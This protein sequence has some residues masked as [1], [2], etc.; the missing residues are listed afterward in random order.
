M[1]HFFEL[2]CG[3]ALIGGLSDSWNLLTI[4]T[5]SWNDWSMFIP[6]FA[7]HSMY[8]IFNCMAMFCASC[9]DT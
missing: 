3:N 4:R 8:G 6:A 5:S 2:F 7:L 1:E 9:I